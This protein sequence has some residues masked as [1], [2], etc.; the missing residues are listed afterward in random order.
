MGLFLRYQLARYFMQVQ[1]VSLS[2]MNTLRIV[3]AVSVFL[4]LDSASPESTAYLSIPV[5]S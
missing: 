2:S 5:K 1:Q 3:F 4:D